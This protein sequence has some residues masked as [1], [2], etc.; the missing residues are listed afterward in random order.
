MTGSKPVALPLGYTPVYPLEGLSP[1]KEARIL[2]KSGQLV[3]LK[4]PLRRSVRDLFA[5]F[6]REGLILAHPA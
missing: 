3:K 6:S 5:S 2:L 1:K 4:S